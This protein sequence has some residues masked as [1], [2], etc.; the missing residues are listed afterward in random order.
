MPSIEIECLDA[1]P[2]TLRALLA[3]T[4]TTNPSLVSVRYAGCGSHS[5]ILTWPDDHD[6]DESF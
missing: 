1:P 2:L 4:E 6:A 3:L 5:I